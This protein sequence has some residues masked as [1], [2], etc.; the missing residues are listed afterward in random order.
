MLS[1]LFLA[2]H[3]EKRE[4]WHETDDVFEFA[5]IKAGKQ[6]LNMKKKSLVTLLLVSCKG[7]VTF[8]RTRRTA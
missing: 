2:R 3:L 8:M 5:K 7:F 4:P 6:L 1:F